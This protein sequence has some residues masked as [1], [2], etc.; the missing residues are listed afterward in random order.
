MLLRGEPLA[1]PVSR[2]SFSSECQRIVYEDSFGNFKKLKQTSTDYFSQRFSHS[3]S[4]NELWFK[5]GN[6]AHCKLHTDHER[7]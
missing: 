7:V 5:A 2:P 3:I 1:L 6:A 4:E